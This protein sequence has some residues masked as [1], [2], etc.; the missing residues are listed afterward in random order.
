MSLKALI[1]TSALL[2]FFTCG[3]CSA[4]DFTPFKGIVTS[5]G[6]HIRSDS[7]VSSPVICDAG[8]GDS[9]EVLAELYEWYKVRVPG[10]APSFVRKDLIAKEAGSSAEIIKERIN[11]RLEPNESSPI[12]GRAI[13][14]EVVNI[15]ADAG[16]WYKIKPVTK[17]FGWIHKRFVQK[18]NSPGPAEPKP[19]PQPSE[20]EIR[21]ELS[22]T[23]EGPGE[24]SV[25]VEGIVRPQGIFF[26]RKTTHKIVDRS[27]KEYFLR[28]D[29]QTLN[30]FNNYRARITGTLRTLPGYA[31]P[32]I[33][34]KKIEYL[35]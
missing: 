30:Q 29:K 20:K 26:N 22:G 34:V 24:N 18:D 7:T 8:K 14:G 16:A 25:S 15:V 11:I 17:S 3:I 5:D 21:K 4:E 28:C 31:Y 19:L 23:P 6:I 1:I 35:E 27:G 13:K 2:I 10:D 9:L 33:E 32:L 12:I